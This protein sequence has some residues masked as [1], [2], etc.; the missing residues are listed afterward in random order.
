MSDGNYLDKLLGTCRDLPPGYSLYIDVVPSPPYS[1]SFSCQIDH[2][3]KRGYAYIN[4]PKRDEAIDIIRG[5]LP[6][7]HVTIVDKNSYAHMLPE[8]QRPKHGWCVVM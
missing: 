6:H 5:Q 1:S 4:V 8:S 2:V 7:H 3:T